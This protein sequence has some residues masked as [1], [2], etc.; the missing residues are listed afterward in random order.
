VVVRPAQA[1]VDWALS[2]ES[3]EDL[4]DVDVFASSN[5]FLIP[6]FEVE[7]DAWAWVSVNCET[8]F[9]YMLHDWSTDQEVWPEDRGWD[10]FERWFTYEHISMAWDL[11]DEPLSSEAP[12]AD[13]ESPAGE[14]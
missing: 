13:E 10:E 3:E 5:A 6:E 2:L 9:D 12:S 11:V 7:D 14:A 1:F 4:S 8:M